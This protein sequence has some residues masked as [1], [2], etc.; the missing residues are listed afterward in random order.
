LSLTTHPPGRYAD[1]ASTPDSAGRTAPPSGRGYYYRETALEPGSV[2][3]FTA[4]FRR[5]DGIGDGERFD[6]LSSRGAFLAAYVSGDISV[7]GAEN[8]LR[9]LPKKLAHAVA[10][11]V[12][13]LFPDDVAA[14]LQALL[15]G[16]RDALWQ[17]AA[18]NSSLAA[19]GIIHVVAISGM[20]VSFLMG[21]IGA[22]IR[23]K[24]LFAI[25]GIPVLLLFMAMTGFTPSVTRAG[26]MQVFLICAPI[27]RRESDSI[28][29]L[30]ASLL[31]ILAVNPYSCASVGL[32]LSFSATLGIILITSRITAGVSDVFRGKRYY[33]KKPIK[34]AI[35]FITSSLATTVGALVLTIPLTVLH[36]GYVSLISPITNLLTLWA[37]SIAFPLGLAACILGFAFLPLGAIVAYPVT[38]AVRYIVFIARGLGA[39]PYS[40]IYASNAHIIFWLAYIYIMFITLPLMRARAR[41]YLYPSCLAVVMLAVAILVPSLL[42]DVASSSINVLDVGQGLSV[43]ITSNEHTAV[44]DCG[45]NSGENAGAIAHEF[46]LDQG[47]VTIDLLILTHFHSDHVNGAEYLMS[48]INVSAL[49]IPDPEGSFLA[50]DIIDLARRRGT[51]I[52]YVTET[53]SVELG[54]ITVLMYPPVGSGDEN[55][56]GLAVLTLGDVSALITGDMSASGERSLLRF[57]ALPHIDMLVV[58]HHGSRNSTSE[59]LLSAVMPKL[60]VIS[61]GRNSYGHPSGDTLS[62]LDEFSVVVYRTDISGHVTV[63]GR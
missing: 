55:E 35:S 12:E 16:K 43:V 39:V 10:G 9:Y 60:A 20:H 63:Y 15:V 62:R 29:S 14:F 42:P 1:T 36:F 52:I 44:V 26:I 47:R 37:V 48:R 5:T 61:V 23:N 24:R 11:M 54:G 8:G 6:A 59:E 40:V 45:S 18:L 21:F 46:L 13:K 31:V 28:T 58:G 27:F 22:V 17:D 57:A 53:L 4:R 3:E 56:R 2:I 41:Q 7:A 33:R 50:D 38:L 32:Q 30:S 19:S 25:I 51:V 34:A 49:A